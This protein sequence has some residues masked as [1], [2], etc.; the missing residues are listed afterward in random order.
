M[1]LIL[2]QLNS[3]CGNTTS[4]VGFIF[5]VVWACNFV[6]RYRR[7]GGTCCLQ[8]RVE[9]SSETLVNIYKSTRHHIPQGTV[10]TTTNFTVSH[11]TIH[12]LQHLNVQRV[13]FT[14]HATSQSACISTGNNKI[15]LKM[16]YLVNKSFPSWTI[17]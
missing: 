17:S 15:N 5:W 1:V 16:Y 6:S 10:T 2:A 11:P 4:D 7:F 8:F 3:S 13:H 12:C 14:K 9:Y